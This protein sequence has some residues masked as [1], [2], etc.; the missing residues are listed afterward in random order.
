MI[1][2]VGLLEHGPLRSYPVSGACPALTPAGA[3]RQRCGRALSGHLCYINPARGS[4]YHRTITS[5]PSTAFFSCTLY[6]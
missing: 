5:Q 6:E 1:V 3:T 2:R 4:G